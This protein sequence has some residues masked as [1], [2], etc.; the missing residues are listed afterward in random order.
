MNA[1]EFFE[2]TKVEVTTEEFE[3]I[4]KVYLNS[5]LD[6]DEFC[7]AWRKMNKSRVAEAEKK[8]AEERKALRGRER[9]QKIYSLNFTLKGSDWSEYCPVKLSVSDIAFLEEKGISA[10]G[11]IHERP[12]IKTIGDIIYE[13]GKK[14]NIL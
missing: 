14:L 10:I 7:A 8:A 9:L 4:Q 12:Y 1:R 6:K 5:D 3:A 11:F 2:R 13:V